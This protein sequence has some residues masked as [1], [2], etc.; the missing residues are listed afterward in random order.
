[1]SFDCDL[2]ADVLPNSRASM[3]D[4]T[5]IRALAELKFGLLLNGIKVSQNAAAQLV[6]TKPEIRARS[7]VSGGLDIVFAND[8]YVNCTT[9]ESIAKA[10]PFSLD[11]LDN[12]FVVLKNDVRQTAVSICLQPAY[13]DQKTSAG[14]PMVKVGQM[15]SVDRI[16]ISMSRSCVFWKKDWRCRFCSIGTNT[17][18]EALI[19]TPEMIAETVFAAAHDPILPA[20]HVL[21]GGG[22]PNNKDRG[23]HFAAQCCEAIKK[24]IDISIYVM[25]APP[26]NLDDINRLHDSGANELGLNI[27][28]YSDEA[29]RQ[30]TP[31]KYSQVGRDHYFKALERAV[32]VFGPVNARAIMIA[33]LEDFSHTIAGAKH[34]ASMGV[35]PIISPFR[36]LKGSM[37]ADTKTMPVD[38]YVDLFFTIRDI[39]KE[40]NIIPGPTCKA[41][42]NNTLALPIGPLCR[43]FSS[44]EGI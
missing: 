18:S 4:E 3:P 13:Y 37:L 39:C 5:N 23:A 8:V 20:R 19:K 32:H 36:P 34:L 21:I 24:Q 30:Y 35:M 12:A 38:S 33:G 17:A 15:C 31:G 22:T 11:F 29:L 27:E 1:M 44:P 26:R 2:P 10:S 28:F 7:G 14:I 42:Q 9:Q 6:R 43:P 41:C 40:Y 16:C 25:I